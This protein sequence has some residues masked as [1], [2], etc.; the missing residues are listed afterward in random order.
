MKQNKHSLCVCVCVC[1]AIL[2]QCK[3]GDTLQLRAGGDFYFDP[4]AGQDTDVLLIAGGVGINPLCSMVNHVADLNASPTGPY[5][6]NVL[7]LYSA[8]TCSELIFRVGQF[9]YFSSLPKF[10]CKKQS[11]SVTEYEENILMH[12]CVCPI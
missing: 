11:V 2:F 6:G 10:Q 5:K 8:K 4:K 7:L 3:P 12:L 1:A 9:C